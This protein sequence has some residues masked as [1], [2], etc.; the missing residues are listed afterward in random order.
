MDVTP[1]IANHRRFVLDTFVN[2]MPQ[3]RPAHRVGTATQDGS[4]RY[5]EIDRRTTLDD[6]SIA[7]QAARDAGL[8]RFD[9]K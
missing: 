6:W 3:Y 2:I 5:A 9:P 4:R 8:W 1:D 7:V